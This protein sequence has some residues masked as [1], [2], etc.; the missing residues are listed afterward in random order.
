VSLEFA[1]RRLAV[2]AA[3]EAGF[4]QQVMTQLRAVLRNV[5]RVMGLVADA[6]PPPSPESVSFDDLAQISSAW[7]EVVQTALLPRLSDAFISGA[8]GSALGLGGS[9][10]VPT[11]AQRLGEEW[12]AGAANRLQRAGDYGWEVA[13][14][15]LTLGYQQGESI[16]ALQA[17]VNSSIDASESRAREVART[18]VVSAANA[19]SWASALAFDA[20]KKTWLSTNDAR[21][22][23]THRAADGQIKTIGEPFMVGGSAM[24]FPGDPSGAVAQTV[25]CRCT[26]LFDEAAPCVCVPGWAKQEL[27][28]AS[29]PDCECDGLEIDPYE[30]F[31]LNNDQVADYTQMQID[32]KPAGQMVS[33]RVRYGTGEESPWSREE[34]KVIDRY[35][36]DANN[37]TINLNKK[38]RAEHKL[39]PKQQEFVDELKGFSRRA[40]VTEGTQAFRRATF[41]NDTIALYEPN[42]TLVDRGFMSTTND[43]SRAYV[44]AQTDSSKG[45]V[46]FRIDL[47]K[48]TDIIPMQSNEYVLPPGTKLEVLSR[49]T[50]D[51]TE[52]LT[53]MFGDSRPIA[54]SGTTM[55]HVRVVPG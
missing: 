46:L 1:E 4:E 5:S 15:Q 18:S 35:V 24:Q 22:R 26:V 53:G 39:T 2:I 47:P 40:Q 36:V 7:R 17:R 28:A 3:I 27:V 11:S 42:S 50:A 10:D 45:N 6:A 37:S 49:R 29:E 51:R 52:S 32:G 33:G 20:K 31:V 41:S 38:L 16:D 14:E 43:P 30:G 34:Q 44:G 8:Q 55:I 13:R 21:T 25:N 9:T 48:G 54:E 19:G 12:L 23:L